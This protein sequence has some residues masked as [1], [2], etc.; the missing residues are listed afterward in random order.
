M[1]P[2]AERARR[3][4]QFISPTHPREVNGSEFTIAIR[5]VLG[6]EGREI[7]DPWIVKSYEGREVDLDAVWRHAFSVGSTTL[8]GLFEAARQ[9]GWVDAE[10]GKLG[11]VATAPGEKSGLTTKQAVS[12]LPRQKNHPLYVASKSVTTQHPYLERVQV[13][14][15]ST[16]TELSAT[17]AHAIA[18]CDLPSQGDKFEGR[19]LV[20]PIKRGSVCPAVQLIDEQGRKA[21]LG[22]GDEGR[23]T[24][25]WATEP[26]SMS[27][28]G[29]VLLG[30]DVVTVLSARQA[31]GYPGVAALAVE[32]LASVADTLIEKYPHAKILVLADLQIKSGLPEAAAV[33]VATGRD[34]VI[35]AAPDFGGERAPEQ[36]TF[37]DLLLACG[38]DAVRCQILEACNKSVP[39]AKNGQISQNSHSTMPGACAPDD[40]KVSSASQNSQNSHSSPSTPADWKAAQPLN[41]HIA[42]EPFPMDALPMGIRGAIEEVRSFTKAPV[43][44]ALGSALAVLSLAVQ[45]HVD[46]QRASGLQGPVSL[47]LLAIADSGERKSTCDRRFVQPVREYERRQAEVSQAAQADCRAS[48]STW[49]A[50]KAGLR[51]RIL[52]HAREGKRTDDLEENL[53]V[54]EHD[55]PRSP[56]VPHLLYQDA[57]PEAL[58]HSLANGWPSGGVLSAEGGIVFGSAAMSRDT[59]MRTLSQYNTYWDGDP[60]S[61]ERRTKEPYIVRDVRLTLGLQV[62]E[63]TLRNFFA[64]ANGL[65]RGNGF[66]ARFLIAWPESTQGQRFF[67]E[68]PKSWPR[69]TTFQKRITEILERPVPMDDSGHLTPKMLMLDAQAKDRWIAFNND[70]ERRIARGGELY[71]VRDLASKA[72]DNAARLAALFH[73]YAHDTAGDIGENAMSSA[74]VIVGWYLS[75]AARFLGEVAL[76]DEVK[77]VVMLNDWLLDRCRQSAV[78]EVAKTDILKLGP[79]RLRKKASLESA[80]KELTE[81]D[82]VRVVTRSNRLTVCLN[83]ELLEAGK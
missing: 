17:Q 60:F 72:A 62:Q 44:L 70:V 9:G 61:I 63:T 40:A 55:K 32:N 25:Y 20:V 28:S 74:C 29:V 18:G 4:L 75:E 39:N 53:R 6:P 82:R 65:A 15:T 38:P 34:S 66:L 80:L 58:S 1:K 11:A 7:W 49:E 78:S 10:D 42:P 71:E 57:T 47:Y 46:V 16:L 69:L 64:Q 26:I 48:I 3:A 50:Q 14:A 56:L 68:P 54:L 12:G 31:S 5:S 73:V 27:E 23:I 37:N 2:L 24:G 22:N 81:L 59:V 41:E 21:M 52:Q 77:D 79:R 43:V 45:A 67:E 8:D 13:S 35:V 33:A 36:V 19:L 51:E 30:V 83:P 76:P